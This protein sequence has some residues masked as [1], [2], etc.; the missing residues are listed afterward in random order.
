MK[1]GET[2]AKPAALSPMKLRSD[3][4]NL[5]HPSTPVLA[6]LG[7]RLQ[8]PSAFPSSSQH[9][10]PQISTAFMPPK[11]GLNDA[12][13]LDLNDTGAMLQASA[14]EVFYAWLGA[15][16]QRRHRTLAVDSWRKFSDPRRPTGLRSHPL[17]TASRG[18]EE[19][20]SVKRT[21][22]HLRSW[23]QLRQVFMDHRRCNRSWIFC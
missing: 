14:S 6:G 8:S 10:T 4:V 16:L 17:V 19:A 3:V 23:Q 20:L 15:C 7:H 22:R 5:V 11:E 18:Q 13:S 21:L 1:Q 9:E 12:G 2:K